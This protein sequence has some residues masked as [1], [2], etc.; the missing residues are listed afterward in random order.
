MFIQVS[1]ELSNVGTLLIKS[2]TVKVMIHFIR[3]IYE[4][5]CMC[6]FEF[7]IYEFLISFLNLEINPIFFNF[8]RSI[9]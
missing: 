2:S 5:I 8:S 9:S 7:I 3:I 6:Y 1:F 4:T